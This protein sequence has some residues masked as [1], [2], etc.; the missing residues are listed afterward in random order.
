MVSLLEIPSCLGKLLSRISQFSTTV[1]IFRLICDFYSVNPA[2]LAH[3][4][5]KAMRL[6]VNTLLQKSSSIIHLA[7]LPLNYVF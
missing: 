5:L 1:L 6:G 3:H 4:C 7:R 2:P